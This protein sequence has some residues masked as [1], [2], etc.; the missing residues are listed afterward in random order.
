MEGGLREMSLSSSTMTTTTCRIRAKMQ[1]HHQLSN[2]ARRSPWLL[3]PSLPNSEP[4][5]TEALPRTTIMELR[6]THRLK[7]LIFTTAILCMQRRLILLPSLPLYQ[8]QKLFS[9]DSMLLKL[10]LSPS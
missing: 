6:R 2:P 8:R 7:Y 5:S 1:Y 10:R 3:I 9:A 4:S